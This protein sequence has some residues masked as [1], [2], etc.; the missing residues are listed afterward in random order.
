LRGLIVFYVTA[1]VDDEAIEIHLVPPQ[2]ES[3][4]VGSSARLHKQNDGHAKMRRCCFE[5]SVFF[6]H[7]QHSLC[8][9][10][11]AF[12]EMFH[13]GSGAFS[14]VLALDRKLEH[15]LQIFKLAVDC[16]SLDGR[17][18]VAFRRLS[19][20]MVPIFLDLPPLN[21]RQSAFSEVLPQ[22]F[23]VAI[24]A[25]LV[26]AAGS[27]LPA[28]AQ[29]F[30]Y[31]V[32]SGDGTVSA[33]KINSTTGTLSPVT[34]SPFPA[35]STPDSVA[36]DPSGKFAY[37]AN[38]GDN[39]VSAYT[40][41]STTGA[42]TLVGSVSAGPLPTS[43]A[44]DPSGKFAYVTN[45]GDGGNNVSAY[46]IDSTT[47]ALSPVTGS[48]FAAGDVP[49]SV[50]VDPSGKFAYVANVG[51][52]APGNVSAYTINSTTGALSPVLG[53]PFAAGRIPF[54]VAADPS[55][56]FEK[57]LRNG[58]RQWRCTQ[59]RQRLPFGKVTPQIIGQ[60]VSH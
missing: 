53:S 10:L 25:W 37:V 8:W 47:G 4:A 40:I 30:A 1:K 43:V 20:A 56:K 49:K 38:I 58:R 32:N 7:G 57:E 3:F 2:G 52:E 55:G 44:V 5:D 15:T 29:S 42:L 22:V 46:T 17:P 12:V 60:N 16:G 27:C 13:T 35:G 6:L 11:P 34:G 33:Y 14:Q 39:T 50:A 36:V 18:R 41:N 26:A 21:L 9:P 45:E 51:G 59:M 28:N 23:L 48:P 19:A 31:V 24:F 54:S